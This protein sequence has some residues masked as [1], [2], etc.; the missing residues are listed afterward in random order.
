MA[1][2]YMVM[3]AGKHPFLLNS[4]WEEM[5]ETHANIHTHTH[6]SHLEPGLKK[7]RGPK[8]SNWT[9]MPC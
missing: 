8:V 3:F 1:M 6:Q 4:S 7:L 9:S 2:R 5:A